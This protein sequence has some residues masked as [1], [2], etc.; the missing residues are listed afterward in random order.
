MIL[1][2]QNPPIFELS[3]SIISGDLGKHL[4]QKVCQ[5]P[6][7]C[8]TLLIY[9]KISINRWPL[10]PSLPPK[11]Y[12]F[13]LFYYF[14]YYFSLVELLTDYTIL[15]IKTNN[16]HKFWISLWENTSMNISAMS[17]KSDQ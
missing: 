2:Y 9:I 10:H 4:K 3:T 1:Y 8:L 16:I 13:D 11:Y 12:K 5:W 15:K 7:K 6:P 17:I 14:L